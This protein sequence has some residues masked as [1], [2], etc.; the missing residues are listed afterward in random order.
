M[1]GFEFIATPSRPRRLWLR[2]LT[3][4]LVAG[5]V[6]LVVVLVGVIGGCTYFALRSFLLQRLDQQLAPI[7]QSNES[8]ITFCLSSPNQ[9]CPFRSSAAGYRS[10]LTEWIAVLDSNAGSAGTVQSSGF[11]RGMSLS[12]AQRHALVD[13]PRFDPQHHDE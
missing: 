8:I 6:A 10:P 12:S 1:T 11:L 2:S 3:S 7:A 13:R 5:V 4:R 9:T